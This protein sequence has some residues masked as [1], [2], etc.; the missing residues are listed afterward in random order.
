LNYSII[1]NIKF[2][3]FSAL[4]KKYNNLMASQLTLDNYIIK[5]NLPRERSLSPP[6]AP[7]ICRLGILGQRRDLDADSVKQIMEAIQEDFPPIQ[8][9]I[10]PS[11]TTSSVY[12]EAYGESIKTPVTIYEADWR[13]DGRKAQIFRDSRIMKEATHFLV[14][15]GP[16]SDRLQKTAEQLSKKGH[17]VFFMPPG[18]LELHLYEAEA[19]TTKT[20]S[21]PSKKPK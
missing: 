17:Q 6:R 9:L 11:D 12:F 2:D 3:H 16:R 18:E 4:Q 14:F 15:G 19:T 10:V 5:S 20:S 1:L 13:R 7:Q 21:K 8:S